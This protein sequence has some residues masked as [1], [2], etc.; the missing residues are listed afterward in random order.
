MQLNESLEIRGTGVNFTLGAI[1]RP[2]D[3]VQL[4]ASFST[5]TFYNL[6]ETYSATMG[7]IWDNFDYFGDG[8][9]ILGDNTGDPIGTDLVTSEYNLT[10]PLKFSTGVAFISKMGFITADVEFVNYSSSKYSADGT[11][12]SFEND[13]IKTLF[14]NAT[15][16][17]V[18]AEYRYEAFRGRLGYSLQGKTFKNEF[19]VDNS[20][21]SISGGVGYRAKKFYIDLAVINSTSPKFFYQPYSFSDGSGPVAE[22][23]PR[24]TTGMITVGFTF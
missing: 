20:I 10:T 13:D 2:V 22:L 7:T 19:D 3:F 23:K 11:S 4:G 16:I 17:R 18:G 15:N 21:T 24:T 8:S 14:K 1:A 12:Y 6:S 9:E 5:P